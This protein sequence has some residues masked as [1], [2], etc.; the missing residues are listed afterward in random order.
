MLNDGKLNNKIE[1][2]LI[3]LSLW[4]FILCESYSW[5]HVK[6]SPCPDHMKCEITDA[7][8]NEKRSEVSAVE[9]WL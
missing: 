9:L 7:T 2:V 1:L 6:K 3:T 5:I 4:L 8:A